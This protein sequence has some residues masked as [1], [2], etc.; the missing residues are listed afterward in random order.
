MEVSGEKKSI[1]MPLDIGPIFFYIYPK[2]LQVQKPSMDLG[3]DGAVRWKS[4]S[5]KS[6]LSLPNT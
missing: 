6:F 4:P 2:L 5:S 3:F 1:L